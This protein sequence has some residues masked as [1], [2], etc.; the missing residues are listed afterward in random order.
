MEASGGQ[1]SNPI[2]ARAPQGS[3][4]GPGS[5]VLTKGRFPRSPA[6][7]PCRGSRVRS[8]LFPR[9]VH[10]SARSAEP[11]VAPVD[12]RRRRW[13]SWTDCRRRRRRSASDP[14][15]AGSAAEA[16]RN[17]WHTASASRCTVRRGRGGDGETGIERF[18]AHAASDLQQ[19]GPSHRTRAL[20]AGRSARLQSPAAHEVK[21]NDTAFLSS[22]R[23]T[24]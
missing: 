8:G 23:L 9:R 22:L 16:R 1:I 20:S 6:R 17:G 14:T 5:G 18:T 2:V 4:H 7:R 10:G 21:R 19:M 12:C 13:F 15:S 24:V 11:F 3:R